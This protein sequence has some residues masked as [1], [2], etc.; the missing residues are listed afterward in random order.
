ML[1][2]KQQ[3]KDISGCPYYDGSVIHE[4]FAYKFF[5]DKVSPLGNIIAFRAP[6]EVTDNLIDLEDSL[7]KDY[8]YSDDA[9]NFC[10]EIPKVDLFGGIC[11]Q[12]LFNAQCAHMLAT[13]YVNKPVII[14]GDDV[15]FDVNGETKKSSVS[16]AAE[17]NGAVL[18]HTAF[19]IHAGT[20]APDFAFSTELSDEQVE[21]FAK[22]VCEMFYSI[23]FDVFKAST[24]I[25]I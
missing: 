20:K 2:T 22:K 23:L 24:K 25:I 19:N 17:K 15:L 7:S 13:Q 10:L 14:D 12:R 6:M 16:I 18:I 9:I 1:I 4:R 8:I 21:E 11:F 5:R 3:L